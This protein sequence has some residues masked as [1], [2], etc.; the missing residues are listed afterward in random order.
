MNDQERERTALPEVLLAAGDLHVIESI[1]MGNIGYLR[2]TAPTSHTI[3]RLAE[4]E[5]IRARLPR[6]GGERTTALLSTDDM[7]LIREA[8]ITFVTLTRRIVPQSKER[9]ETLT[10]VD[11]LREYLEA[12]LLL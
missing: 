2:N 10:L 7:R 5:D 3:K 1:L 12:H 6:S 11:T 9:D 4:L 8:M